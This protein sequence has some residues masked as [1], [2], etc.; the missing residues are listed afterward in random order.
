MVAA[1]SLA[2]GIGANSA[3]FSLVDAQW[4]RPIAVPR[5]GEIV[6]VFSVTDQDR[7]GRLS[8]PEYLEIQRQASSL[9]ET[10]A[11][12]GRGAI[13]ID[14]D[15]HTLHTLYLVSSNFFTALGV[16]PALGRVFTP[17]DEA[18][19]PGDLVVVLG[20]NFWQRQY[21]GDRAIVG[22]RIHIQRQRDLLVTVI[23]VLPASF[24][25]VDRDSERDMWFPRQ[26]WAQLGRPVELT[27]P[28]NRW[29]RVLGR[30]VP[31][32]NVAAA[33]AQ[34]QTVAQ[35]MAETWPASNRGRRLNI[36]SDFSYRME[37]AGTIGLA[38]LG[39][40]LL[41]VL[42]SSVNV[43]NLLLSR[44]AARTREMAVR[45][46]I[47]AGRARLIR[48]LMIENFLLGLL[49]LAMG[50]MLGSALVT[51][52]PSLIV[53]PPGFN[54]STDFNFDQ[55]VLGFSIAVALATMLL[56]GLAPAWRSTRPDLVPA[57]KG[58]AALGGARRGWPL[59]NWLVV[60]QVAVSLTLLAS[61]SVLFRSFSKTRTSDL[62]FGRKPLLLVWLDSNVKPEVYREVLA[63][64][65]GL[66]GVRGV[67]AAVRAPLSLS[68]NGMF[69]LITFPG[70]TD[71]ANKPPFEIKYNAVTANFLST[72]GTPVVRGRGI[73]RGDEIAGATAVLINER[74][75]QQFWPG[76]N[77]IGKSIA[78]GEK[79]RPQTVV[80]VVKNAP[81]NAVG[82]PPEPYL[83]ISYWANFEAECTFLV[84]TQGDPT[85]LAQAA[86][87]ALKDVNPGL[88][89]LSIT[90]ENE[91]IRFSAQ[92]FQVTAELAGA[93]GVL[94]LILTA[95]G[96]YGVVSFSV[97]QRTRELGIRMALGA[98]R[99]D[100]LALV[101]REVALLGAIGIA[102][103][104]PLALWV[105]K[106]FQ[107][108]LFDVGPWDVPAFAVA[109][110]VLG[111][112]LL[113]AGWLPARRATHID[114][115]SA[116]RAV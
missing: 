81:I 97:G 62:G 93:L 51:A 28:A 61:A 1:L 107:S 27:D 87:R 69:Q 15:S 56:F 49:G 57:L 84:E 36:V 85:A 113:A 9:G 29:F 90:T 114:P 19:A 34:G 78:M 7:E 31:S 116:L 5:A 67:A 43:A 58:E 50:L 33:N 32:G 83:Y 110:V 60:A 115:A 103:G 59:R 53:Q 39:I 101:L 13:L 66:P 98:D 108:M 11:M 72:M 75:A 35:R 14:G 37:Q 24:R 16:Q 54:I 80:G 21:G 65:E 4:F 64:F 22:R 25:D 8:Y 76:E 102:C 3:I 68:S 104:L 38:L 77:P 95:V 20:H 44:A 46:A 10:V 92:S 63:R 73:D 74:M 106:L 91:L 71:L 99:G 48:Q 40:V 111:A 52:L 79:R 88:D 96:L 105:T 112:V 89:P 17:A 70:R 100:T 42:I 2:L 30:L 41:V 86:R 82:E 47:G 26:T 55:R 6:R 94:G 45:L 23:G 12:G 18:A 109:L